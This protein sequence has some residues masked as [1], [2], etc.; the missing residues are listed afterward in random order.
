MAE[1]SSG[2]LSFR[3]TVPFTIAKPFY[4]ISQKLFLSMALTLWWL[5]LCCRWDCISTP[6][7]ICISLGWAM[8]TTLGDLTIESPDVSPCTHI[9]LVNNGRICL[10][11]LYKHRTLNLKPFCFPGTSP[12][13]ETKP[14]P[15]HPFESKAINVGGF[16]L[17]MDTQDRGTVIVISW[18]SWWD[19]LKPGTYVIMQSPTNNSEFEFTVVTRQLEEITWGLARRECPQNNKDETH[20]FAEGKRHFLE[21]QPVVLAGLAVAA[22]QPN[23]SLKQDRGEKHGRATKKWEQ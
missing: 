4:C 21:V 12:F 18:W 22:W 13:R 19:T 1:S 14:E 5:D 15:K 17:L 23:S 6:W 16:I 2:S 7:R 8:P 3:L 20:G 10:F 11:C 9:H